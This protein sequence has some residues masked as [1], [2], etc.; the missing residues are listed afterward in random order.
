M[1]MFDISMEKSTDTLCPTTKTL[2]DAVIHDLT[3]L[4]TEILEEAKSVPS[5]PTAMEVDEPVFT[6]FASAVKIGDNDHEMNCAN[7][8]PARIGSEAEVEERK[9]KDCIAKTGRI[10]S[11]YEIIFILASLLSIFE[12]KGA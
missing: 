1:V 4:S 3:E 9:R 11:E 5:T 7:Q 12:R 6:K 2:T 10:F 8:T